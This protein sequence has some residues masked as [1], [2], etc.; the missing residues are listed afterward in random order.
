MNL[1]AY[2][3]L[4]LFL[5]WGSGSTYWYVC[6]IKGFCQQQTSQTNLVNNSVEEK[7]KKKESFVPVKK[8]AHAIIYFLRDKVEPVIDDTL[9]WQAEVKSIKQ[10]QAEGKKLHIEAPFYAGENN[11]SAY[12]NLGIA[13]ANALKKLLSE[14]ID[15]VLIVPQAKQVG[16][17]TALA[18]EYIEYDKSWFKWM[19]DNDFVQEK[20]EKTLIHFPYNST[21]AIKNEAILSYL[22]EVVKNMKEHPGW[23]LQ[24]TGHTD[25][26]GSASFN[27]IL[28]MKRAKRLKDW[29]VKKGVDPD[30]IIVKSEGEAKPIAGNDTEEGRQK[31][32]RV[33]ISYI[34]K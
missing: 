1:K 3:I 34:K 16:D 8:M 19:T 29:L 18:P 5:L 24:I 14:S 6:K 21:K 22:D 26:S 20:D 15:T 30:R 10:L 4:F 7:Q 28:G 31:N 23:K 12:D 27:K 13:R 11:K 17:T 25:D 9:Q 2:I 32:R 33:E